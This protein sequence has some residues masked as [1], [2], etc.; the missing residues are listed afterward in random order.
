MR[1]IWFHSAKLRMV[2][3]IIMQN[4]RY[5]F[6]M[7][8]H[9]PCMYDI[10]FHLISLSGP[11]RR[12]GRSQR[13]SVLS[14]WVFHLT[15]WRLLNFF[16]YKIEITFSCSYCRWWWWRQ[17]ADLWTSSVWAIR[18]DSWL[19]KEKQEW[20]FPDSWWPCW[21]HRKERLR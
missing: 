14:S 11:Q 21:R 7:V 18:S 2:C 3:N 4:L 1:R 12:T 5:R 17:C 8:L 10:C 20:Y 19:P 13:V 16:L 15:S 9:I 6:K